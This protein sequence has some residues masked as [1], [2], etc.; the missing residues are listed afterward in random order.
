[1]RGDERGHPGSTVAVSRCGFAVSRT[2][3][4][5]PV[6]AALAAE[7]KGHDQSAG[8]WS[9]DSEQIICLACSRNA[10]LVISG[11]GSRWPA[12]ATQS[13]VLNSV[14]PPSIA[15]HRVPSAPC[16]SSV[17]R[18]ASRSWWLCPAASPSASLPPPGR[19]R[20]DPGSGAG[21]RVPGERRRPPVTRG[22]PLPP[23]LR[24]R[25]GT[26]L[27]AAIP[28]YAGRPGCLAETAVRAICRVL[29]CFVI[30]M[31]PGGWPG[32]PPGEVGHG[33]FR[34]AAKRCW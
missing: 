14:A 7:S 19:R 22:R 18:S 1:M 29:A 2:V 12:R 9:G 3:T 17:E 31:P 4:D 5:R 23:A 32:L 34:R 11:T 33:D 6:M 25:L 26:M 13:A 15:R 16:A 21:R 24:S 30:H 20:A 8:S 27:R 28:V 10:P